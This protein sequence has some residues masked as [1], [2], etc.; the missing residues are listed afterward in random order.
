MGFISGVL[1]I[2]KTVG[3]WIAKAGA[4]VLNVADKAEKWGRTVGHVTDA[5][6]KGRDV[7]IQEP[8]KEVYTGRSASF[9]SQRPDM[10]SD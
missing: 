2:V 7:I 10:F 8:V 3:S 5:Y 1:G 9:Q 6:M 4:S